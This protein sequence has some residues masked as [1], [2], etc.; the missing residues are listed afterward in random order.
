MVSFPLQ[1]FD[2]IRYLEDKRIDYQTEGKNTTL[3]WVE[4]N[5]PFCPDP[6]R[7]LGISPD[8]LISCWKCSVKGTVLKYIQEVEK[9]SYNYAQKIVDKYQDRNIKVP[10][11]RR[12]SDLVKLPSLATP[13]QS[14]HRNYLIKRKFDP[15]YLEKKYDLLGCAEVGDY[16]FRIIVPVY[17][18]NRLVTFLARSI[19]EGLKEPYKNAPVEESVIPIKSAVYNLDSVRNNVVIVEGVTDVWRIGEG[20]V[21]TFGKKY[22]K[23]QLVHFS[24]IKRAFILY[25]SDAQKEADKLAYDLSAI[26]KEVEILTLSEGDPADLSEEDVKKLRSDLFL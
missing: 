3:G 20:A 23:N 5:C 18:H 4:V 8:K 1:N 21:A 6:S 10:K 26:V 2:I 25:D 7:H 19:F 15:D 13:L 22:T 24:G 11:E 17:L 14:M 12:T 9:C 16:K